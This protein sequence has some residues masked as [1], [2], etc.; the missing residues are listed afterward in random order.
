MVG[1]LE[2]LFGTVSHDL[3]AKV[4]KIMNQ[5][6]RENDQIQDQTVLKVKVKRT[7]TLSTL[8]SLTKVYGL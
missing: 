6:N 3:L 8:L 4:K 2:E 7:M 1:E 5:S